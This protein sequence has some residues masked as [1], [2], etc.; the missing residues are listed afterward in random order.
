MLF[1]IKIYLCLYMVQLTPY[2]YIIFYTGGTKIATLKLQ[3]EKTTYGREKICSRSVCL[4]APQVVF[5]KW[6]QIE[7]ASTQVRL[8]LEKKGSRA[9]CF[10]ENLYI[11]VFPAYCFS[12]YESN[13]RMASVRNGGL[14]DA[15]LSFST[16]EEQMLLAKHAKEAGV[17]CP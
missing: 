17:Y 10:S 14:Q 13:R 2:D 8:K 4:K 15:P 6:K 7:V 12:G 9:G 11:P 16:D 1:R 5:S 3:T